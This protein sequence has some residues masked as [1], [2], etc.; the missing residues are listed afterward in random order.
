MNLWREPAFKSWVEAMD[1]LV[2]TLDS[3]GRITGCHS[4]DPRLFGGRRDLEG[5]LYSDVLPAEVAQAFRVGL[6]ALESTGQPQR[7]NYQIPLDEVRR[8]FTAKLCHLSGSEGATLVVSWDVTEHALGQF[9]RLESEAIYRLLAENSSDVI[10]VKDVDG[11]YI[12]VSPSV[13]KLIDRPS[14][15]L[16]GRPLSD[17]WHPDDAARLLALQSELTP[18]DGPASIRHRVR[19]KAGH[20]VW[21]ESDVRM[22]EWRGRPAVLCATRD[23]TRRQQAE[24][25]AAAML[26]ELKEA[27]SRAETANCAKSEFLANMSHELRTP[28]HG[29]LGMAEL[30]G[31]THLTEDQQQYL[32]AIRDSGEVLLAL[33]NDTNDLSKIEAGQ[34]DLQE[35]D[36]DLVEAVEGL[37]DIVGS[38]AAAKGIELTCQVAAN[39]PTAVR[40]DPQRLRQ[41][42][43]SLINTAIRLTDRGRIDVQVLLEGDKLRFSVSDIGSGVSP[44]RIEELFGPPT[45]ASGVSRARPAGGVAL[46][47][48][49]AR[50]LVA[51]MGGQLQ[52]RSE[53]GAG[54][55]FFFDLQLPSSTHATQTLR[56]EELQGLRLLVTDS[57]P[58][59]RQWIREV[60][61]QGGA[62]VD[63]ASGGVELV[64]ALRDDPGY[65]CAIIDA[66]LPDLDGVSTVAVIRTNPALAG[67]KLL[68]TAS[69][70]QA[71]RL[72]RWED[73]GAN[74]LLLRPLR[75]D[76]LVRA[77]REVIATGRVRGDERP[78]IDGTVLVVEDNL[79]NLR[80]ARDFL[81]RAGYRVVGARDAREALQLLERHTIDAVLMDIQ[82]PDMDGLEATA[83]IRQRPAWAHIPII[84]MTAHAMKGDAERFLRAGLDAYLSKPVN[85]Q[86]LLRVVGR[87]IASRAA[88]AKLPPT[89]H[90][91]SPASLV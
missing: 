79:L 34:V 23:I 68:L 88:A 3:A 16:L 45:P 36:F 54:S 69:T 42:L 44:E 35:Q 38:E 27:R 71:D 75:R 85:R 48:T 17:L 66:S 5:Q 61:E 20:W 1:D 28:L 82:L 80:L 65:Q 43:M 59:S 40:G 91:A 22:V 84:A 11:L 50:K 58:S 74:G 76:V 89:Q 24:E 57:S 73:L 60:L 18:S 77:V 8:H 33:I 53:A 31:Q 29:I 83:R 67:L 81:R 21:V 13:T 39:V 4:P 14:E 56:G 41:V 72:T 9:A 12:Y 87:E 86:E 32:A 62:E 10:S 70:D 15:E 90:G 64:R 6:Q 55:T 47:L 63:Q 2:L 51:L 49:I 7:L 78:V 37:A 25:T 19:H 52:A 30:L 46:G 26:E